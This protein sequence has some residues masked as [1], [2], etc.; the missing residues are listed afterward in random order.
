LKK[1][2]LFLLFI[3]VSHLA[4][5]QAFNQ[6]SI[7]NDSIKCSKV[8]HNLSYFWKLDS[9]ANNGFRQITLKRLLAC[10][11]DT[12]SKDFLLEQLGKPNKIWINNHVMEYVYF[13]YDY[14][15]TPKD[16]DYGFSSDCWYISFKFKEGEKYLFDREIW[17]S[18][19]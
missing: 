18:Q 4:R 17:Y 10:A 15:A 14:N 7:K 3:I 5:G 1:N 12:I 8:L 9:L 11:L 19:R 13:Y 2:L 16:T 6:A